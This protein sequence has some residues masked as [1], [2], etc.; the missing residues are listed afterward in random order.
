MYVRT[1]QVLGPHLN[2]R[3]ITGARC[4]GAACARWARSSSRINPVVARRAHQYS[5]SVCGGVRA[6]VHRR[7]AAVC[8]RGRGFDDVFYL[9]QQV[10]LV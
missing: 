1:I 3:L 4:A 7:C 6:E 10:G 2:S 5:A 9:L 8:M